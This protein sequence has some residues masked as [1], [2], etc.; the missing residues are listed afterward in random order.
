[1]RNLA[2]L[3]NSMSW[4]PDHFDNI[5]FDSFPDAIPLPDDPKDPSQLL[6]AV[7]ID[8]SSLALPSS[9][10]QSLKNLSAE[11]LASQFEPICGHRKPMAK[12]TVEIEIDRNIFT[13]KLD[14]VTKTA[15][16]DIEM[17][18]GTSGRI[19]IAQYMV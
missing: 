2:K 1:V 5:I 7:V 15:Y 8:R 18:L 19:S 13:E 17:L 11:V 14:E 6:D 9:C 4:L 10:F 12:T 3:P 16:S